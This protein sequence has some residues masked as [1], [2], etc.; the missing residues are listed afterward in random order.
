MQVPRREAGVGEDEVDEGDVR[1][2]IVG[3]RQRLLSFFA[4][5]SFRSYVAVQIRTVLSTSFTHSGRRKRGQQ[6]CRDF[7]QFEKLTMV[8]FQFL[9]IENLLIQFTHH[10]PVRSE[11]G[12]Y[13]DV[14]PY[15]C[16]CESS[17]SPR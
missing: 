9:D 16:A 2:A 4:R 1:P 3:V 14:S 17:L 7:S 12:G 10:L 5:K 15:L 11:W 8:S 6:F 13:T